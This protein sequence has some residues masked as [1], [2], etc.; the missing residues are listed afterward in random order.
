MMRFFLIFLMV[1]CAFNTQAQTNTFPATGNVGIGTLS[2]ENVDGWDKVIEVKGVAHSKLLVTT[3]NNNIQTGMWS[4]VLGY[5][6]TLPGG[7]VGTKTAHNFSIITAGSPKIT[8]LSDGQVGIGTITPTAKLAVN[9]NIRAKEIKVEAANWPDFVFA[10]SYQL[11]KL[12]ETAGY[13]REKG[14]L[15]GIPSA[16]EVKMNGVDLGDMNAKLLQKIE[17]LTLHLIEMNN[18]LKTQQIEIEKLKKK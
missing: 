2:P 18:T 13:I 17:E 3:S 16:A 1:G 9:G 6:G 11:P 12:N 14:H 10:K 7:F 15:P 8:V 4:H 5:Y